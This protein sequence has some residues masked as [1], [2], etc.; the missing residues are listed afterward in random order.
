[1]KRYYS[2]FTFIYPDIYLKNHVVELDSEN[3][4][5]KCFPFEKEIEKTEFYSGWLMFIPQ[6]VQ[7]NNDLIESLRKGQFSASSIMVGNENYQTFSVDVD[8]KLFFPLK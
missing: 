3:R 6:M 4:I 1:M 7:L 8:S 5:V 2:H